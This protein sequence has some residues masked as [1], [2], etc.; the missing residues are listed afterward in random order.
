MSGMDKIHVVEH[1]RPLR[2]FILAYLDDNESSTG[3]TANDKHNSRM[4]KKS[5]P[6]RAHDKGHKSF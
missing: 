5:T 1:Q 2:K 4:V 6:V 3:S